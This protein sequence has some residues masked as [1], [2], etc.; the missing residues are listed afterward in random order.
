MISIVE[1]YRIYRNR[2]SFFL[3]P[4]LNINFY[5]NIFYRVSHIFYKFKLFPL[6]K[7]FW[8]FNRIVFS[9]DIDPG[10]KLSGGLEIVHGIGLVIGRYVESLGPL[11][12]YHGVTLGGNIGKTR[13]FNNKRLSQPLLFPNIIIGI[14]STVI[15]PIVIQNDVRIGTGAIITKDIP[16]GCVVIGNNKI[17]STSRSD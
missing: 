17:I 1:D 2:S 7:L 8:L 10:A 3:K 9:V 5:I 11:K 4:F 16:S 15:G 14:N 13:I 12:V 6:A